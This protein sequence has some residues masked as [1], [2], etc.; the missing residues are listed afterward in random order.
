[1]KLDRNINADGRGKYGLL[2]NREIARLDQRFNG[3][4]GDVA[5]LAAIR[6]A[7]ALLERAGIIDWGDKPETAFFVI[8]LKD[9]FSPNA[10]FAYGI[11]ATV[12]G[13]PEYGGE[14]EKLARRAGANH[15]N[16][17]KPD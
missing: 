12:H 17:K 14:I 8:R 4:E 3:G 5:D 16:C 6:E 1:M 13:D 10:L 9:E 15:P 2:L 7:I 11:A